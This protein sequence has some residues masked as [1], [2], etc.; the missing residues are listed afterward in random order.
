MWCICFLFWTDKCYGN[1]N[2]N[3]NNDYGDY[4]YNDDETFL[5]N[6]NGQW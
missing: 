1:N 3:N 2:N 4:N 6:D 5:D